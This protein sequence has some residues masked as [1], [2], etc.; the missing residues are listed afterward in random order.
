MVDILCT[1]QLGRWDTHF[2]YWHLNESFQLIWVVVAVHETSGTGS[3]NSYQVPGIL[4]ET[5]WEIFTIRAEED[6]SWKVF[7]FCIYICFYFI[8]FCCSIVG[9]YLLLKEFV[10]LGDRKGL[11]GGKDRTVGFLILIKKGFFFTL[12]WFLI[13]IQKQSQFGRTWNLN[14]TRATYSQA[15]ENLNSSRDVSLKHRL[16][17]FVRFPSKKMT[18]CVVDDKALPRRF[19][20]VASPPLCAF[21]KVTDYIADNN[22]YIK[23]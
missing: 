12:K 20:Q 6:P 9:L 17:R 19:T 10:F 7:V 21:P 11:D 22:M 14:T 23:T 13:L 16:P 15:H 3:S 8:L 5:G 4:Q 1:R 2:L 18:D